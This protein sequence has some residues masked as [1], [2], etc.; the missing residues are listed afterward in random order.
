[1]L[2]TLT[3]ATTGADLVAL[4]DSK[5]ISQAAVARRLKH[6]RVTIGHW[7]DGTTKLTPVMVQL[8]RAAVTAIWED[9]KRGVR[10]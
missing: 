4:R 7:E 5:G 6:H 9:A 3:A 1:M 10:S 8:Y 2:D